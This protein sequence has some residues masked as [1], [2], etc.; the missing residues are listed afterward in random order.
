MLR[1]NLSSIVARNRWTK[2]SECTLSS[3]VKFKQ[4]KKVKATKHVKKQSA[5]LIEISALTEKKGG[6]ATT[7]VD[8]F[9][10]T[11]PLLSLTPIEISTLVR[12]LGKSKYSYHPSQL[13][14]LVTALNSTE[15]K[16]NAHCLGEYS[17]TLGA[18]QD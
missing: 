13:S 12:S 10:K 8:L 1:S 14:Q 15:L 3:A 9:L 18:I 16:L 6:V 17:V 2:L 5:A 11:H 4:T 7:D